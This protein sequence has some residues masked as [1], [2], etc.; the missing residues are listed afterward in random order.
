MNN[1]RIYRA[2]IS[3]SDKEGLVD[4]AAFLSENG[5]EIISTGGTYN[6]IK[7]A[8]I[9]VKE[10]SEYTGFPEMM[11]G[12]LK[13]LHPKVH[14]GLLALREN[15]SHLQAMSIHNILPID[16]VVVNLYPFSKTVACEECPY[17]NAIENIDIGG[18]TMIRSAAKNHKFV[19]VITNN[20]DYSA[21][22]KELKENNFET[23]YEFRKNMAAKA[24]AA[25]A[26][27]DTA[28]SRW[29]DA[30][31]M[32]KFPL[33]ITFGGQIK[34]KLRYG[35]N[36]HQEAALY[37]NIHFKE[38]GRPGVCNAV[39]LQGKELSYNNLNDTDAAFELVS[40]FEEPA[41]AIIK[42]ATPCGVAVAD[43]LK[44]AYL[45]AL[46]C[47]SVSAFG[48][49]I[50]ANRE[51]DKETALE[52]I[53]I[54]TEVI[55]APKFS[56]N[57]KEVFELKKNLRILETGSMPNPRAAGV[58]VKPLSGGFIV[59]DKDNGFISPDKLNTV[60]K[61]HPND[62]ELKDLM[63][64]WTVVKHT[65]SNAIVYVK[66]GA[67]VGIGGGQTSRVDAAKQAVIKALE[68][69]ERG[70]FK[71]MPIKGSV[72]A[73]DAFFPFADGLLAASN[74]GATAI[75]QPGGSIKDEEVIKAADDNNLAMLFTGLRHF[76]HN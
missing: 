9:N 64:A 47:D 45:K 1:V 11:D 7:D 30:E 68:A 75:I 35:E 76:K 38:S 13:T 14:G 73:S 65:K 26:L 63:V 48:G 53:K 22:I 46:A 25:T 32:Q 54:F 3:I 31:L 49:I 15:E 10:I 17:E 50:A 39:Q 67:T 24:F 12:R 40:E 2:L 44:T 27:Y 42:H 55:I 33:N 69:T 74:A 16:L 5:V 43:N 66:D 34:Q 57:A 62:A 37:S 71:E 70:D 20:S 61:R 21:L 59:Q 4:L 58:F 29:F 6:K 23:S 51:I 52:M 19:T 8:G 60:T 72:V 28:I 41:I 18:P 36:P 56:N